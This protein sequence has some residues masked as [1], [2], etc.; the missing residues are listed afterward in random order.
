MEEQ[1]YKIEIQT[2]QTQIDALNPKVKKA[3]ILYWT[4]YGLDVGSAIPL[5]CALFVPGFSIVVGFSIV[6]V[7]IIA[8]KAISV[9]SHYKKLSKEMN[10][11]AERKQKAELYLNAAQENA[12]SG[13]GEG[14]TGKGRA[15]APDPEREQ[16]A[17]V[18]KKRAILDYLPSVISACF[19][20]CI[21][22]FMALPVSPIGSSPYHIVISCFKK[23]F[24]D[25]EG[26]SNIFRSVF[27][28]IFFLLLF[29]Y[30]IASPIYAAVMRKI[31]TR[32][33]ANDA[34]SGTVAAYVVGIVIS[35]YYLYLCGTNKI[36]AGLFPV[37]TLIFSLFALAGA[38]TVFVLRTK[39]EKKYFDS[40]N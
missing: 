16:P 6:A 25:A 11:L 13:E 27:T 17:A 30:S 31:A 7:M 21:V 12:S 19:A 26:A 35:V 38:V 28:L 33:K 29:V 14:H 36:A 3:K 10:E 23:G 15:N 5:L 20:V 2:I 8:G 18:L 22:A 24:S 40:K 32:K 34:D 4:G 39:F 1:D 9:L 37:L